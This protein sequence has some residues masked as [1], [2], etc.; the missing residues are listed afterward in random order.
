MTFRIAVG[1]I[2]I[3]CST[4]SPALS[5]RDDFRVLR[6]TD[7]AAAE[8]FSF[9]GADDVT[10]LPLLHARLRKAQTQRGAQIFAVNPVE[11][12]FA[13]KLAGKQIVAPIKLVVAGGQLEPL[14]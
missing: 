6:G 2:H 14:R 7:L 13:F 1:G 5:H 3:E 4:Y 12:D 9:L 11:F 8:Y 10:V